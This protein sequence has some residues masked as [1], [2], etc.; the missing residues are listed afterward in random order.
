MKK[1]VLVLELAKMRERSI[2]F[3]RMLSTD[4]SLELLLTMLF[5]R[6]RFDMSKRTKD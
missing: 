5:R 3:E 4:D 2:E 1:D 6:L